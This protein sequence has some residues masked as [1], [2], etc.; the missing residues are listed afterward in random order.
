M[1]VCLS[2]TNQEEDITQLDADS[3]ARCGERQRDVPHLT[4]KI[5]NTARCGH[6]FCSS[7]IDR[8]LY[9]K[10]QFECPKCK[11]MV[12]QDKVTIV[13]MCTFF[14]YCQPVVHAAMTAMLY[15][16]ILLLLADD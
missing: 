10:R 2:M 4:F 14:Y 8:E 3:C 15:N 13:R 5:N 6:K 12:S 7:C 16:L 1:F 11:S 9:S